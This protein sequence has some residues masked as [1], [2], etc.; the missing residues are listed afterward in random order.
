MGDMFSNFEDDFSGDGTGKVK[1][2]KPDVELAGALVRNSDKAILWSDGEQDV[3]IPKSQITSQNLDSGG[4]GT[5]FVKEWFLKK[6]G[7]I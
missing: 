3:W 7:L 4:A 1:G 2:E 5:I 6:E